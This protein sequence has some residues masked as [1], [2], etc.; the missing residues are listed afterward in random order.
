MLWNT[1]QHTATHTV[2]CWHRCCDT[3][4]AARSTRSLADAAALGVS[5][6]PS[7]C[8]MTHSYVWHSSFICVTLPCVWHDLFICVTRLNMSTQPSLCAMIHSY[9]WHGTFTCA[10]WHIHMCDMARSHV[11]HGTF[12]CATWHI[13]MC[14]MTHSCAQ[15]LTCVCDTTYLH[16]W[17]HYANPI[18]WKYHATNHIDIFVGWQYDIQQIICQYD[19]FVMCQSYVNMTYL[20]DGM[21]WDIDM[22]ISYC[23]IKTSSNKSYWHMRSQHLHTADWTLGSGQEP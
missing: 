9:L 15:H 8:D 19:I 4:C 6:W 11:R 1:L 7:L 14:G 18:T 10:T 12:T 22:S 13:H 20:V 5:A 21:C 16:A 17:Y 2:F 3:N 23:H